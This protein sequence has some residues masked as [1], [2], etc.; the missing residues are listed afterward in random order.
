MAKL[1]GIAIKPQGETEMK[2]FDH[3]VL[4]VDSG[5]AGDSRGK[6][7][8]RQVT[9]LSLSAWNEACQ[10]LGVDLEWVNRR[11]NLL[12]NDLPLYQSKGCYIS[13][14]NALLEIT[15]ETDPCARMEKVHHGL[16]NALAKN[17]RGGVTCRVLRGDNLIKGMPVVLNS[18]RV[19][20][21]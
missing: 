19:I 5:V 4:T 17:W 16:F 10:E 8:P 2:L 21:E 15:G 1:L 18:A 12:V 11:A 13:L 3:A 6:P 7:G 9:V 20:D 14:G